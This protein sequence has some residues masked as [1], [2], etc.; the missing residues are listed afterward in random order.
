LNKLKNET[1]E[2][3]TGE[4]QSGKDQLVDNIKDNARKLLDEN[5]S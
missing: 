4:I 1:K 2:K 5:P 3:I